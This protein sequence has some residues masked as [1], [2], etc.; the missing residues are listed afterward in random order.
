MVLKPDDFVSIKANWES[1]SQNIVNMACE[2]SLGVDSFVFVDDNPAEREIIRQ[3]AQGVTFRSL[4]KLRGYIRAIDKAG[5][6]EMTSF[7]TDDVKRNE[8]YQENTKRSRTQSMFSDYGEYL[9]ILEMKA[10]IDSFIPLY[11]ERIA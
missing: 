3:Q 5:Y 4:R 8:I 1:K 7:S 11:M 6:F 2:L 9:K 10:E